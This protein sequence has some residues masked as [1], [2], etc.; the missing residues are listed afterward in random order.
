MPDFPGG[1]G[2]ENPH[3]NMPMQG[4]WVRPLVGELKSHTPQGKPVLYKRSL[5]TATREVPKRLN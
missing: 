4:T 2:I 1:P 5:R 3:A